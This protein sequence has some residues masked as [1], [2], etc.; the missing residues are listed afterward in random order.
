MPSLQEAL[1]LAVCL[2][3]LCPLLLMPNHRLQLLCLLQQPLLLVSL[4]PLLPCQLVG[5]CSL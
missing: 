3:G 1:L 2:K 5:A 4:A